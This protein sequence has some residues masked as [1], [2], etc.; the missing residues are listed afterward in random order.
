METEK[1]IVDDDCDFV[2][3][4][5]EKSIH[6]WGDHH[7]DRSAGYVIYEYVSDVLRLLN[8][9]RMRCLVE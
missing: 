2:H 9:A 5:I 3:M 8:Y 6:P 1:I 7:V 4:T